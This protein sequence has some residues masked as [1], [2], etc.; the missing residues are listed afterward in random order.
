[1]GELVEN[2]NKRIK[3]FLYDMIEC[4]V[5]I[6]EYQS[7]NSSY[8]NRQNYNTEKNNEILSAGK[9]IHN[10]IFSTFKTDKERLHELSEA[11][12]ELQSLKSEKTHNGR[13]TRSQSIDNS[14]LNLSMSPAEKKPQRASYLQPIMRYKPRTNLER[15]YD[16]VNKNSYGRIDKEVLEEHF[17]NYQGNKVQKAEEDDQV[18]A[19]SYKDNRSRDLRESEE[20][21][22]LLRSS[23]ILANV[24][25]FL[26]KEK[27]L[28]ETASGDD[29]SLYKTKLFKRTVDNSIAKKFMKDLHVKTHF[30]AASVF[31]LN[32]DALKNNPIK[33]NVIKDENFGTINENE[34]RNNLPT[35][36]SPI[37]S[38]LKSSIKSSN[39]YRNFSS[40]NHNSIVSSPTQSQS[41]H[42]RQF[43][44][45]LADRIDYNMN[46]NP[47]FPSHKETEN[48]D[49]KVLD[50]LK[51]IS[52]PA[53]LHKRENEQHKVGYSYFLSNLKNKHKEVIENVLKK[54]PVNFFENIKSVIG[55]NAARER[56]ELVKKDDDK[57]KI[58]KET[59]F[60]SQVDVIS[61]N[62]LKR[63][64]YLKEKNPNS[65]GVLKAGTGKLMITNGMSL[66]DFTKKF[67]VPK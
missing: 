22:S 44:E 40:G 49:H 67:G 14:A 19:Y 62:V 64:N 12:K 61:K 18:V 63:C 30:K 8:T 43:S 45:F 46:S 47:L 32:L 57:I 1:V 41:H 4:P 21:G 17:R 28:R 10:F 66:N 29:K 60:R 36:K 5:K 11:K 51:D 37:K 16:E 2:Y 13:D 31:S 9:P 33:S 6:N 23:T 27:D 35:L 50:Y 53:T 26:K 56:E 38:T 24:E 59:Y 54:N 3:N 15:L 20:R 58:G 52:T 34:D 42:Q 48:V 7:P 25:N 39:H 65:R 55:S